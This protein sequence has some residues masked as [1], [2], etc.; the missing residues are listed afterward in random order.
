MNYVLSDE[1]R[2]FIDV[3]LNNI[4]ISKYF[5]HNNNHIFDVEFKYLNDSKCIAMVSFPKGNFWEQDVDFWEKNGL[6][7]SLLSEKQNI[8]QIGLKKKYLSDKLIEKAR[9]IYNLN[10]K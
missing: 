6:K 8:I 9:I 3:I 10:K 1:N 4:Y 7:Y 2:E 5:W